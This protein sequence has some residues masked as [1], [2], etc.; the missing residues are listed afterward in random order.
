MNGCHG[1]PSAGATV[2]RPHLENRHGLG[3]HVVGLNLTACSVGISWE[4]G[5][6]VLLSSFSKHFQWN[7]PR[8]MSWFLWMSWHSRRKMMIIGS[9]EPTIGRE[10]FEQG[11]SQTIYRN[12][13][14]YRGLPN[15]SFHETNS[16]WLTVQSRKRSHKSWMPRVPHIPSGF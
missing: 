10:I 6:H 12:L 1:L 8:E 3:G 2:F 11:L 13:W 5:G 4:C 9:V 16:Y 15:L 7:S 14:V